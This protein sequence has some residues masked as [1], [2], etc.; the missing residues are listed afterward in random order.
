M[1]RQTQ[2]KQNEPNTLPIPDTAT[3]MPLVMDV[4]TGEP[5]PTS[6]KPPESTEAAQSPLI[7]SRWSFAEE[8]HQYIREYIHQADQKA[9]FFFA[10]A[11]TL[12]AFLY[13]S[14]LVDIWFKA[15]A[16]WVL[17]DMLS[18]VATVSLSVSALACATTVLPRLRGSKRGIVF[19][20]AIS[21]FE[22]G[23]DYV[24]VVISKPPTELLNAKLVHIYDLAKI[25][26]TKFSV[27]RVGIWAGMIG[28]AS[29]VVLLLFAK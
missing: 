10:G 18:F 23:E 17:L 14:N 13:N 12:I 22:S 21:E 2:K 26:S 4:R 7:E 25:C 29:T 8:T 3:A 20:R 24:R 5:V 16:E 15:P 28:V 19:F 11:T 6:I 1:D 9:V 27:L